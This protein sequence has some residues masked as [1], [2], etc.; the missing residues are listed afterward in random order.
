MHL[1]LIFSLVSTN[2]GYFTQNQ[3]YV[4]MQERQAA[5]VLFARLLICGNGRLRPDI[6]EINYE[7]TNKK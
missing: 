4:T 6:G 1:A 3:F 5:E 2:V 7:A